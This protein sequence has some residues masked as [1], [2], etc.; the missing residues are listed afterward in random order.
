MKIY[1]AKPLGNIRCVLGE[2]PVWNTKTGTLSWVDLATGVLHIENEEGHTKV[3]TCQVMGAAIPTQSG[4]FIGCLTTGFYLLDQD[5]PVKKL[6]TPKTMNPR[7]RFNDAKADA[8]GRIWAGEYTYCCDTGKPA[9]LQ[10]FY[11]DG[12]IEE[13]LNGIGGP[14]GM[15]WTPD[16]KTF[17]FIDTYTNHVSAFD[18]DFEKP[19]ITARREVVKVEQGIPDGMTLDAEGKLWVA[20]WGAGCVARYDAESGEMLAKIEVDAPEVSSC[21]FGGKDLDKLYIT[22]AATELVSAGSG[23]TY[24]CE[25]GVQ[26]MPMHLFDDS[27]LV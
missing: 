24:V 17:Y 20:Q 1:N 11:P 7:H 10:V 3:Q 22:T 4:R 14:N 23:L 2:G 12:T 26:G 16:N 9:S 18:C 19:A 6:A 25:P 27:K 5:G 13:I 15:D 8:A 21:C